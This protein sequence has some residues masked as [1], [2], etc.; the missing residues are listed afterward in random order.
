MTLNSMLYGS[1]FSLVVLLCLGSSSET[2]G[3]K[4]DSTSNCSEYS[5]ASG[6]YKGKL[7]RT[8]IDRR[9]PSLKLTAYFDVYHV[10]KGRSEK[11]VELK[12][13]TGVECE[14]SFTVGEDYLIYKGSKEVQRICNRTGLLSQSKF[15]LEYLDRISSEDPLLTARGIIIGLSAEQISKIKLK[16]REQDREIEA[17]MDKHG[18]FTFDPRKGQKYVVTIIFPFLTEELTVNDGGLILT[19]LVKIKAGKNETILEY[20]VMFEHTFC[21][22]REIGVAPLPRS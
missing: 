9:T 13:P 12:F 1:V 2:L 8:E 10:Y 5:E 17:R 4:C 15:D 11:T 16:V 6:V 19:D 14:R 7:M 3:C 21:D 22:F 20:N 18:I